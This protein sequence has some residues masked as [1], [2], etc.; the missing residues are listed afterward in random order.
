MIVTVLAVVIAVAALR[1]TPAV[2]LFAFWFLIIQPFVARR[3]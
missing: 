2:P 3:T 1:R